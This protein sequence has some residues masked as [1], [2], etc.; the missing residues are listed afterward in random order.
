[1]VGR[2]IGN[3]YI[4]TRDARRGQIFLIKHN[5]DGKHMELPV[6]I[7]REILR[8]IAKKGIKYVDVVI[9]GIEAKSYIT[10]TKVEDIINEGVLIKED[11]GNSNVTKWGWQ[12]VWDVAKRKYDSYQKTII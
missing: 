4:T 1:V 3:S 9:S 5:F 7:Q 11:R 8:E 12:Y 10:R 2:V 6:A